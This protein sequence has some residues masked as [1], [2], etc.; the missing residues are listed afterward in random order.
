MTR[1][2]SSVIV[3][4]DAIDAPAVVHHWLAPWACIADG[5]V[6]LRRNADG[7]AV[8]V[9]QRNDARLVEVD[10]ERRVPASVHDEH[11]WILVVRHGEVP[12]PGLAEALAR[13]LPAGVDAL[14]VR[15]HAADALGARAS[16]VVAGEARLGPPVPVVRLVRVSAPGSEAMLRRLLEQE[17][18]HGAP[19]WDAA[20]VVAYQDVPELRALAGRADA[21]SRILARA[22]EVW[23]GDPFAWVDHARQ[24]ASEN[25]NAAA[26]ESLLRGCRDATH[27]VAAGC[28]EALGLCV[29]LPWPALEEPALRA[30]AAVARERGVGGAA[31]EA[32]DAVADVRIGRAADACARLSTVLPGARGGLRGWIR[33]TH[34]WLLLQCDRLEEAAACYDALLEEEPDDMAT[35]LGWA[36]ALAPADPVRVLSRLRPLLE[37]GAEGE[38]WL[39][40]A[41]A[42]EA[43]GGPPRATSALARSPRG[44]T[45]RRRVLGAAVGVLVALERAVPGWPTVSF[46]SAE[47][48]RTRLAGVVGDPDL[49][50]ILAHAAARLRWVPGDAETWAVVAGA[51][52]AA[53]QPMLAD[54]AL[55]ALDGLVPEH[56]AFLAALARARCAAGRTIGAAHAARRLQAR[57]PGSPDAA[58]VLDALG[59][60]GAGA[61]PVEDPAVSAML[62]EA[63]LLSVIVPCYDRPDVVRGLLDALSLQDL[64]RRAFEVI[65][66]DDGTPTPIV[67]S[68][69]RPFALRWIRQDNAGPAAARNHALRH[70]R[71]RWV[72]IYNDDTVPEASG[73]RGHLLAQ[74]ACTEETAILGTF[75]FLP[76]LRCDPFVELLQTTSLLFGFVSLH[77]GQRHG[78]M[79]FWTCNLSVPRAAL[80]AV[81]GFD[82]GFPHAL[83]EDVELGR[84]LEDKRGVKV[85]YRPEIRAGH[86]HLVTW[87]GYLARSAQLGRED[88]RMEQ[89]HPGSLPPEFD[90]RGADGAD[91]LRLRGVI[92]N[93]LLDVELVTARLSQAFATGAALVPETREALARGAVALSDQLR[94][95]GIV[96]AA[97]GVVRRAPPGRE[98]RVSIVV[99]GTRG[100]EGRTALRR[101]VARH[102]ST[103]TR[104]MSRR[105]TF[106]GRPCAVT[107]S[108]SAPRRRCSCHGGWRPPWRICTHGP[109]SGRWLSPWRRSP[110]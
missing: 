86:D 27:D 37:T 103:R 16:D 47:A 44:I 57:T 11:P 74:A 52:V 65:V 15:L 89:R 17:V 58:E 46:P 25:A 109:T 93:H 30:L 32:V 59:V 83:H 73:L 70:A 63:P 62:G 60:H 98:R 78:W 24:R 51:L 72:V 104:C 56:D 20:S 50:V 88:W 96:A 6:L 76:H 71:G 67:D 102:T 7:V 85:L 64:D 87:R 107:S 34:A 43:L 106:R 99:V 101:S 22:T 45:G 75:D 84:R 23:P 69:P 38:V 53:G 40:V 28:E 18:A 9:A 54:A 13:P 105:P 66:V 29:R 68:G 80:D 81:G 19:L 79:A 14:G 97:T 94:L 110:P 21:A 95:Q 41:A 36:E 92:E 82:E 1:L 3:W 49:R 8:A 31:A 42:M 108:C 39:L 100:A 12:G 33:R 91:L 55:G 10:A 61:T 35:L 2:P 26:L 77:P 5:C 90:V 4:V 48:A